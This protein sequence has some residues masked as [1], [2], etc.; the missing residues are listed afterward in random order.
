MPAKLIRLMAF[1]LALGSATSAMA[2]DS[3]TKISHE[4]D[5]KISA[6]D[7]STDVQVLASNAFAGRAPG[8]VG[9]QQTVAFVT[10]LLRQSGLQPGNGDSWV[11]TV[12]VISERLD[13]SRSRVDVNTPHGTKTLKLGGDVVYSNTTGAADFAVKDSALVFAGY[14]ISAPERGWDDYAG[15][16]VRG[17][18]VLVL[19]GLPKDF[20]ADG[21]SYYSRSSYKFEEAARRGAAAVLIVHD[22][23]ASGMDWDY[24]K[25]RYG[26]TQFYLRHAD[27]PDPWP[28]IVG[29]IESGASKSLLDAAGA[30]L[31]DLRDAADQR[32]FK[33]R[34][35]GG[36]TLD[37][38]VASSVVAGETHN[39][40]A[41][42][43]G[44]RWPN[45]AVVYSA[46]WDHFGTRAGMR[47]DNI[48]HGALDNGIGVAA[49]LEIAA[50]FAAEDPKPERTVLFLFPTL[51]EQG[52]L[53]S[54][55]YTMHPVIPD[56]QTV[57]DINFDVMVPTGLSRNFVVIGL[58]KTD[59]DRWLKP[60]V[61]EQGRELQG[62]TATDTDSFFRSDHLSFARAGVPTMYVRGGNESS[63][64]ATNA[65]AAWDAFGKRYHTPADTFDS[66]WDL[67]GIVQDLQIAYQTGVSLSSTHDWPQWNEDTPF[68]AIRQASRAEQGAAH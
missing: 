7:I 14:G 67:R 43:T 15:L 58:H 23:R 46:H 8:T 36:A 54:K 24:V 42:I 17:K 61:A 68:R 9:E 11:Q 63:A 50:Q 29:W 22:K 38:T 39:V 21:V 37:A 55:Y 19:I 4:Y 10:A 31:R 53:G 66:G 62:E 41:K 25:S 44:T 51:E 27:D 34:A 12:P 52:L 33:A 60:L 28:P 20:K 1:L 5:P 57:L 59:L 64:P 16:D 18:T 26:S 65:D 30:S 47:G 40:I 32:G 45:E 2:A 56:A 13:A 3:G 48:Y 35:L 49:V 6:S